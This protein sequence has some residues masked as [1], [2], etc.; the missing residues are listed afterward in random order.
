MSENSRSAANRSRFA[1]SSVTKRSSSS[2][3]SSTSR[4]VVQDGGAAD[5]WR[6]CEM[7]ETSKVRALLKK[8]ASANALTNRKKTPLHYAVIGGS[9]ELVEIL[10]E[11]GADKRMQDDFGKAPL[12]YC[13][14]FSEESKY[15]AFHPCLL[16]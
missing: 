9:L 7:G 12:D 16:F 8:G 10:I 13:K 3:S 11:A 6:A 15:G 5:I 4:I 14:M 1:R 2:S